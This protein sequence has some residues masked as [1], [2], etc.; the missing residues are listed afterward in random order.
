[1]TEPAYIPGRAAPRRHLH[2]AVWA[3]IGATVALLLAGG[4][5]LLTRPSPAHAPSREQQVIGACE[6]A[7]RAQLKSPATAKF[8]GETAAGADP[9]WTIYGAV[10]AQ[11]GFGALIRSSLQCTIQVDGGQ[12]SVTQAL[13]LNDGG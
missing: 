11:N 2:P 9:T 8:T 5:Y 12:M 13:L 7:I 4:A 1:M 10:D 3:A 6:D